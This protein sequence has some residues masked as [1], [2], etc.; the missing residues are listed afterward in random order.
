VVHSS[1]QPIKRHTACYCYRQAHGRQAE[2]ICQCGGLTCRLRLRLPVP[3]HTT[4]DYSTEQVVDLKTWW[5][6]ACSL[7]RSV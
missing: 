7:A 6:H 4:T 1:L 2:T 5:H 3:I